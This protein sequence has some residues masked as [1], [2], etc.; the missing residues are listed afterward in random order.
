MGNTLIGNAGCPSH[1]LGRSIFADL[2]SDLVILA[3]LLASA[4]AA[5]LPH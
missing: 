5:F 1:G 3:P 4:V 2:Q